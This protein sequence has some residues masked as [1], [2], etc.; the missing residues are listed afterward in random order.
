MKKGRVVILT[1]GR[2]AGKKAVIVKQTDEGKKVSSLSVSFKLRT[3][4]LV[5][6]S[7]LVLNAIPEK[8]Q[9]R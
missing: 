4:S 1:C 9:R 7:L 6:L 8:S 3:R 5:T 2:Q